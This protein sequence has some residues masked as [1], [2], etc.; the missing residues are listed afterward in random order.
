ML[1]RK[2]AFVKLFVYYVLFNVAVNIS[3]YITLIDGI[4]SD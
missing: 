1:T 2:V 4:I 3:V